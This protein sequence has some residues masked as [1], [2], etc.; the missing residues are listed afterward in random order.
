MLKKVLVVIVAFAL[1]VWLVFWLGTQAVS[2]FWAGE[3]VTTSAARPWPGGMGPLDTVAGR[4]P[5]QP[6]ND[7]S[8]KLTALVNALP[9]NDDAGEF[10]WREI[11]RGELSIGEPPTLSDIAGIRDLLLHEQIVWERREGLGDSQ[12]SAMR[13]VQMMAARALVASALTKARANDAAGWD[14]LHAAWNLARSLDGQPQMMARTAAFSIVRMINAVAWKMP[15]PAP[16]W[17][18]ELQERDDLR[19]LLEGFQ[20]QAASYCEGSERMLPTKWLAASVER[21]RRIA[22]ALFNETRCEVTTPMNDLGTD[23]SSVWRRAFRYR[24]EREAT[25]NALRV[26]E[27]KAI[28]TSSRC[29]D[30]GWTFD[31]TTLRF[32]REIATAAP[33]R[34]MPL[35]LRVKPNGH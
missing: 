9:K 12:T 1:G 13:A 17:Y 23:L 3:A 35:V 28:E 16:A 34:P 26:R 4:Y 31:G 10:V 11:A 15:L 5:S 20:H 19:P 14:D 29:S 2:W 21:D 8:I 27:G 18:A 24:A 22:E 6:A 33:D 25:A 30:G 32:N 7:A